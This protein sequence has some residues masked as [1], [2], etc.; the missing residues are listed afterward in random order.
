MMMSSPAGASVGRLQRKK[1]AGVP[2]DELHGG[3]RLFNQLVDMLER[4]K[5]LLP[6]TV[7]EPRESGAGKLYKILLFPWIQSPRFSE[8]AKAT[9]HL[10]SALTAYAGYL[11]STT[12][13]VNILHAQMHGLPVLGHQ[14]V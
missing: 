14:P 13:R 7:G 4:K 6:M 9:R 2:E 8:I 11:E 12:A 10:A 1:G 5:Y 3:W